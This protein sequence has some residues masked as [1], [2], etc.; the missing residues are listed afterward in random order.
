[1]NEEF[2]EEDEIEEYMQQKEELDAKAMSGLPSIIERFYQS[3][4]EVSLRNEIPAAI[5]GFVLLGSICKDFVKI[6]NGRN[7][8]DSRIHFC[9]VQAR[10]VTGKHFSC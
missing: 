1:M 4:G 10:I 3:A 5:S 6:P 7:I 8:E 9:W 2:Y